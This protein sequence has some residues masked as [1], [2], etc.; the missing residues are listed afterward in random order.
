MAEEKEYLESVRRDNQEGRHEAH[1]KKER[2]KGRTKT[3]LN[4][5]YCRN[6]IK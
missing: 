5:Y 6:G 3:K 1:E 4:C 2:K